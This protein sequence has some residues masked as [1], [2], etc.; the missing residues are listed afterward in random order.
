MTF[1][2]SYIG[3]LYLLMLFIPNGL[4]S[5]NK[6]IDYETHAAH[7]NKLL[8]FLERAGELL[9]T[10]LAL[11]FADFN[12]REPSPW[13]LWLL[14]S[15]VLMLLYEAYWIRYFRSG[16]TLRDFYSSLLGIPVAGATL[17]VAAFFLLGIYGKNPFLLLATAILGIG[18]IGIH[19]NHWKEIQQGR[20]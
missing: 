4:W 9:V 12:I 20:S 6:P 14:A 5:R 8:V 3:L 16:K 13:S 18:H 17:P 1:G 10:C 11:I 2:F 15:F 7:E 19:L